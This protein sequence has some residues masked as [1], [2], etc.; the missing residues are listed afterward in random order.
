MTS[1]S[2][3]YTTRL[4]RRAIVDGVAGHPQR[5]P[6][7]L[8]ELIL[9]RHAKSSWANPGAAD[10]DRPLNKRGRKAAP[11]MAAW[12]ASRDWHPDVVLCSAALRTQETL[13]LIRPALAPRVVR[14]E[15]DLYLASAATLLRHVERLDPEFSR[16]LL[17]AHNPGLEVLAHELDPGNSPASDK[18]ARKFPTAAMAWF[19]SS[20]SD[21]HGFTAGTITFVDFMTPADQNQPDED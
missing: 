21:W 19:R 20:S 10:F 7:G 1:M 5:K 6:K 2:L 13:A 11:A 17:L 16:A 12:L 14:I 9:F 8:K 15:R 3:A 18:L 4:P